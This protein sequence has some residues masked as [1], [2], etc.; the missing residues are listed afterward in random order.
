MEGTGVPPVVE[1][2][3]EMSAEAATEIAHYHM[4][5]HIAAQPPP[6]LTNTKKVRRG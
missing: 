1:E 4:A 6:E 5:S 2:H 3:L